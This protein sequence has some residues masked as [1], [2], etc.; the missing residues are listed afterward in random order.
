MGV[1]VGMQHMVLE[2]EGQF[3]KTFFGSCLAEEPPDRR[4]QPRGFER[5]RVLRIYMCREWP[6]FTLS[7]YHLRTSL[8]VDVDDEPSPRRISWRGEI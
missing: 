8:V 3:E 2:D 6:P 5:R 4:G 1:A 7:L